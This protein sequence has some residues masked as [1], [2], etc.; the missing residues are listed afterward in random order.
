M[1]KIRANKMM[2][3]EEIF[4]IL[5]GTATAETIAR[6]NECLANSSEYRVLFQEYAE[7]HALLAE[8]PLEKTAVNFTDK[9]I[10]KWELSQEVVLE[11]KTSKLPFYFLILS[12]ILI[13]ATLVMALASNSSIKT[14]FDVNA[15]VRIFQN[16]IFINTLLIVNTLLIFNYLD[17]K[18]FKPYFEKRYHIHL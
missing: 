17:K 5:D 6:H 7:M 8:M 3:D 1:K 18:V 9:L 15:S 14:S 11:R 10:D 2:K 4:D 13:I 12:V 16:R